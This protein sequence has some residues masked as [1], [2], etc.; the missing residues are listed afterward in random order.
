[1]FKP[2]AML[3][4][5]LA[6]FF[7]LADPTPAPPS[8]VIQV[9]TPSVAPAEK[10]VVP[11]SP[12]AVAAATQDVDAVVKAMQAKYDGTRDFTARFTQ[13]YTYTVLRRTEE[14]S[15]TVHFLKPGLMRWDYASPTK[16]S[17][18]IDGAALWIHQPE[19]HV[20]LVDRCFKED[21]LTA[22][23]AFLWGAGKIRDQFDVSAFGG[24]FGEKTDHHLLLTPKQKNSAFAKLILVVD[25]KSHRVKQS[26]VVDPQGNVNQFIYENL[27]FNQDV[28][29]SAFQF[30]PPKGTHVSP[31]PGSCAKKG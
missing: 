4:S 23:V 27:A 5:S 29:K 9:T 14:S 16:K 28:K 6:T 7:G 3:L 8:P 2:A 10:A 20:A 26:V 30:A 12:V 21:A 1:M 25:P 24:T 18:I 17:F 22:S 19:D 11:S 31:I 15:G 13:R